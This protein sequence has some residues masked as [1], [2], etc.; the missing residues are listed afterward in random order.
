MFQGPLFSKN[1]RVT[2]KKILYNDK[3]NIGYCP[4]N[5]VILIRFKKFPFGNILQVASTTWINNFIQIGNLNLKSLVLV[6]SKLV[7]RPR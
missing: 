1:T 4:I 7:L 6:E 2:N 3:Y 5:K